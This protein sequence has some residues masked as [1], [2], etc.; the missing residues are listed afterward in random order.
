MKSDEKKI[1]RNIKI[2]EPPENKSDKVDDL[3]NKKKEKLKPIPEPV[4][5][6]W[7]H[8]PVP[9]PAGTCFTC[10]NCFRQSGGC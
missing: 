4:K 9:V 10:P 2:I 3:L 6:Q 7:C 1:P 5:C 8:E